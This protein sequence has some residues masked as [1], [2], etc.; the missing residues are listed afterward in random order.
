M[1]TS[2]QIA[3]LMELTGMGELQAYRHLEQ[4]KHVQR[5]YDKRRRDAA[6]GRATA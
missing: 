2:S 6:Q 4:R 1:T 3:K 5:I